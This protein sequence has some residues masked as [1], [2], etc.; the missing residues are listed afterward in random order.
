MVTK[1]KLAEV[2]KLSPAEL[3][4]LLTQTMSEH[5]VAR[6]IRAAGVQ[7]SA[8]TLCR[9]RN[10]QI[11]HTRHEIGLALAML[12]MEVQAKKPRSGDS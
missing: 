12:Y 8:P 7:T 9:I 11:K 5:E 6:R 1:M 10:G 2:L 4:G 3:L